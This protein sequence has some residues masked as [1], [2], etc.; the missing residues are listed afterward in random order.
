[1]TP[2]R[3]DQ[4]TLGSVLQGVQPLVQAWLSE[5]APLVDVNDNLPVAQGAGRS[6]RALGEIGGS[7]AIF[8]RRNSAIS[9]ID[10]SFRLT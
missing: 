4:A 9:S 2:S 8:T 6:R 3:F 1:M 7:V 5:R 10:R